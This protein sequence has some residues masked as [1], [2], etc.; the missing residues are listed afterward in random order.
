MF[1][2]FP[3]GIP[4]YKSEEPIENVKESSL[5]DNLECGNGFLL[6]TSNDSSYDDL[7]NKTVFIMEKHQDGIWV[8]KPSSSIDDSKIKFLFYSVDFHSNI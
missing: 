5:K 4:D 8:I 2:A 3:N 1:F 7:D 6:N